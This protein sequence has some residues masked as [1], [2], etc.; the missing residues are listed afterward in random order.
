MCRGGRRSV[1]ESCSI[2]RPTAGCRPSPR[3]RRAFCFSMRVRRRGSRRLTR[4]RCRAGSWWWRT[5]RMGCGL[6]WKR[7]CRY[8]AGLA[9]FACSLWA[10]KKPV[11][12]DAVA[13]ARPRG[14]PT[15]VW[16]PDGK[17]FAYRE[18]GRLWQYDVPSGKRR[19]LI[20]LSTLDTKAIVPPPAEVTDWQNRRVAEQ[21]VQW[22]S[23]GRE[24]LVLQ[25]G[26]LFLL[27]ADSGNWNQLTATAEP[28]RDPKLSP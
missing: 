22:S 4:Y 1:R 26:D 10:Q 24:L 6:P 3:S 18:S 5:G 9:V 2:R 16:A 7:R 14:A 19:E 28:E 15:V 12:L 17:R 20:T 23:S 13:A 27:Q 11:T 8:S 25:G 21:T